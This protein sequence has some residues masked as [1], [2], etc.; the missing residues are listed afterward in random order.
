MSLSW[1]DIKSDVAA[2][3]PFA[4]TLIGGPAGAAVGGVLAKAL[5]ADP[6]PN[7]VQA[8]IQADPAV[9]EKLQE[10]EIQFQSEVA[11]LVE[12]QNEATLQADATEDTQ[13][14]QAVAT[15]MQ[16]EDKSEHFLTYSWRPLVGYALFIITII[17]GLTI[18]AAYTGVMF[19]NKDPK[20]LSELPNM[21]AALSA[22][23][24]TS[25]MPILGITAYHRGKMQVLQ[26]GA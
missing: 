10:A 26:A 21:I 3:A 8:A 16:A 9:A 12:K 6:T 1:S 4:G 15:T 25:L 20:I 13:Q 23:T 5:G 18:F 11:A 7:A 14:A 19:C 2:V 24:G 22:L 17:T